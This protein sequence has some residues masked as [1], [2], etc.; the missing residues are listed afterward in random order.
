[1]ANHGSTYAQHEKDVNSENPKRTSTALAVILS[2]LFYDGIMKIFNSPTLL[3]QF[4]SDLPL[5]VSLPKQ[6]IGR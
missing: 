3:E 6:S 4:H 5:Q 1:M 2:I